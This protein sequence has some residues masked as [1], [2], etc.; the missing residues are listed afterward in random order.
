[1]I[2]DASLVVALTLANEMIGAMGVMA[3]RAAAV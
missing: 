2:V 1:M 3:R